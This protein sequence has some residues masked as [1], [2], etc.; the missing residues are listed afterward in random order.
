MSQIKASRAHISRAAIERLYI[1]MRHLLIRGQY[2]PLGRSGEAMIQSLNTLN[3]EIYGSIKDPDKVELDG[4]L[5]VFQRLPQGIEQC[6]YIKLISREGLEY[7]AFTPL[8]PSKRRRNCYRIDDEQMYIE[9]TR[10]RSDVY[11][12]LTHLTF[13]YNES[14]KI[15]RHSLNSRS[16]ANR[17]WKMLQKILKK[18]ENEEEFDLEIAMTYLSTLLGRSYQET[19]EAYH[20]F[21]KAKEVNDL[22]Q[23]VY[24]MG[25][26]SIEESLQKND[27]EI[28]FSA[29]LIEKMGHHV[30]GEKWANNIKHFLISENL[31][32]RPVHIISANMHSVMNSLYAHA[33]LGDTMGD[34]S[35]LQLAFYLSNPENK[36]LGET[37]RQYA[38]EHG[39]YELHDHTGTNIPVQIVDL[40]KIDLGKLPIEI[41][42]NLPKDFHP[43]HVIVVMDYAFGEQAYETMDELLKPL[44]IDGD[45]IPIQVASVNI[46]G[47]AGILEGGKGDIM[48]ATA[49]VMEGMADNY[50][51]QNELSIADFSNYDLNVYVGNMI[52]VLGTSLQN[53]DILRYFLKSS[54]RAIGL[55]M[56]GAHYQKAIQ[57]N[58]KVRKSINPEVKVRYAY[59]ASDNPLETGGTLASGSLG[60]DGVKPT[61][62][63][64]AEILKGIC[65]Q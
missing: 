20:K 21:S 9:M 45:K 22:F 32:D 6:R 65:N 17:A 41:A 8:I 1:E 40:S 48:L 25:K 15:G 24:W 49:H 64:T 54:W 61:Y 19:A 7:S 13:L 56:E 50:P 5:Y 37:V 44:D 31:F 42:S 11:D 10:G 12:I 36:K 29:D 58:S 57:A 3:P 4:L 23:I 51:F 46:M 39:M 52:T 28:S 33:A 2:K 27:R 34:M 16:E 26:L 43:D 55:E 60:V 59:Y 35:L 62:A 18:I 63:I 38:I 30:Y 53:E 14:E 47:K